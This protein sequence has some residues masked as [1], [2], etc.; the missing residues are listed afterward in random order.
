MP[1][2][3]GTFA[4]APD[5]LP[6]TI[7]FD[8]TTA[9]LL[10]KADNAL[11]QLQ[12]VVGRTLNPHL[13]GGP[14]LRR[15]AIAS[16][17][18]EGTVTSPVELAVLEASSDEAQSV[19]PDTREVLN[20]V[21][22]MNH[23]LRRLEELPVC[24]RLVREMHGILMKGVRGDQ[25]RPGEFRTVQNWIGRGSDG[26]GNARFVPPPVSE[27]QEALNSFEVFVS[28]SDARA[29]S[30]PVLVQLAMTHYQFEAIHP[31]RDGNGRIGRLLIPLVLCAREKLRDPILYLS[32]F[33]EEHK[34]EYVDRMLAV[35][36]RG[37]W[38]EWIRFFLAAVRDSAVSGLQHADGLLELRDSYQER[39]RAA[40]A[41]ALLPK[42]IDHVFVEPSITINRA[43]QVLGVTKASASA[44]IK[45]L[46]DAGLLREVT[47]RVRNQIYVAE[48]VLKFMRS[49]IEA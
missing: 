16:S 23:G 45:K 2:V 7:E 18:I 4:F 22:A 9:V 29:A 38:V 1:T 5:P 15:E 42:L 24:L 39:F 11:G 14:L 36:Q 49:D 37:E 32:D 31:F 28:G 8:S 10:A 46:V 33:F 48:P 17:R 3:D 43:V 35:S 12:G 26:I 13:V 41:S 30:Y 40:R 6:P 47:G 20:Y 21:L 27:M 44:N 34:T 19:T 25:E